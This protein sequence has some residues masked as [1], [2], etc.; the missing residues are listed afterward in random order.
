MIKRLL[1]SPQPS[2]YR[3]LEPQDI[4]YS[5]SPELRS[6]AFKSGYNLG[7]EIYRNSHGGMVPLERVLESAGFGKLI[8]HAFESMSTFTSYSPRTDGIDLG[9]AVHVF[10]SGVIS[11]YLSAHTGREIDVTETSCAFNGS[12]HCMFVAAAESHKPE[13]PDSLD[14]QRTL[15]A[16]GHAL[17]HSKAERGG[18]SYYMLSIR[19]LLSEPV[20]SEAAKFLYLLGKLVAAQSR[21]RPQHVIASAARLFRLRDAKITLSKRKGFEVSMSYDHET[22]SGRFVDLSAAFVSGLVK[23]AYGGDVQVSR[24]AGSKGVYGVKIRSAASGAA[25]K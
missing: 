12:T 6:L 10:D 19:P 8:Y 18:S 17:S 15:A 9:I 5:S 21:E 11:G 16:L 2:F 20:F 24:T 23:G 14:L 4:L 1:S 3:G 7:V 25:V 13:G 22:S